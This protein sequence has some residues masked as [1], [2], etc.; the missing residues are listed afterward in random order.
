MRALLLPVSVGRAVL[1]LTEGFPAGF[2]FRSKLVGTSSTISKSSGLRLSSEE[3][4]ALLGIC[5]EVA[6][7]I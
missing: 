2:F 3:A 1:A 7:A 5:E 4:C 6:D